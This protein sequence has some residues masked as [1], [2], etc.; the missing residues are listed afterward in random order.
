M[1]ERELA[2]VKLSVAAQ[3]LHDTCIKAVWGSN[4][5]PSTF[6]ETVL[7]RDIMNLVECVNSIPKGGEKNVVD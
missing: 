6:W 3:T 2:L 5:T 1:N 7:E 4:I